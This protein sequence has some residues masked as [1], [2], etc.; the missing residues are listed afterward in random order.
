[1][2]VK[3][4][5]ST[6]SCRDVELDVLEDTLSFYIRTINIAVSRDLDER[7]EGLDVARGTGQDHHPAPCRQPSGYTALGDRAAHPEGSLRHGPAGRP[8]DRSRPDHAQA[9]ARRQP[10]A[11]ALYHPEGRGTRRARCACSSPSNPGFL[12][13]HVPEKEQKRLM[14][15]L[16]RAYRRIVGL[17]NDGRRTGRRAGQRVALVSGASRGIGAAIARGTCSTRAG[18]CRSACASPDCQTGPI[19]DA[20]HV[21]AYDAA[22]AGSEAGMGRRQRSTPSAGSTR[23]IANAGIMIPKTV[24]EADDDDLDRTAR[25]QRQGAAPSGEG[26]LG[27]ACGE[28]RGPGDHPRL[29]LGQAGQVRAAGFYSISKFAA[30]ALCPRHPPCGVGPRHSRHGRLSWLRRHRHGARRHRSRR[31][32]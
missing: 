32:D 14:D 17:V 3:K 30:V 5:R 12:R 18:V 4:T 16:R 1:M 20:V 9:V 21:L 25:D 27:V 15:I 23:S 29:A 22:E 8:D 19:P 28:R 26:G 24:I 11:G 2:P 10:R 7:L 31:C 13:L 6:R